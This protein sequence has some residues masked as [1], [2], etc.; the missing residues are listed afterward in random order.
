V[1]KHL[2]DL[3]SVKFYMW[4]VA[5]S[6]LA[7]FVWSASR[8][9]LPQLDGRYA[10]I[11]L[12]TVG[13][14]SRIVVDIQLLKAN[15]SV[16][17]VFLFL[18]ALLFGP[19]A[20][21]VLAWVEAFCTSLRFA[22]LTRI[23]VFNAGCMALSMGVAA[24]L[25][26]YW[27][28][29]LSVLVQEK[30]SSR[31]LLALAV[32]ALAHYAANSFMISMGNGL[33]S[34]RSWWAVWREHYAWMV[35]AYL[36]SG[37]IA[38]LLANFIS[39][40]SFNAFLAGLPIIGIIYLSYRNY[41]RQLE[42]TQQQM[43][44]AQLHLR[45]M[46]ESEERFRAAFGEAPIGMALASQDGRWLQVNRSLRE[47]FGYTEEEFG[48]A[49]YQT[50][51]HPADVVRLHTMAGQVL[52]RKA[53]KQ[54]GEIRFFHRDGAEV[55]TAAS[56][57]LI[58]AENGEERLIFQVQD[59]TARR[60]AE[61]QLR[62]AAFYDEL[63]GLGNRR[64]FTDALRETLAPVYSGSACQYA[65]AFVDLQRFRLV[66]ERLGHAVGDQL[67]YQVAQRLRQSAP[68][69]CKIARL[70]GDE[71]T[72]LWEIS[73][74]AE[75]LRLVQNLHQKLAECFY[76]NGQEIFV[77]ANTGLALGDN[78][79]TTPEE[80]LRD[81]DV[82]LQ[83]AKANETKQYAVFN[84]AMREH[85]LNRIQMEIDLRHALERQEF[86]PVYQPIMS[87]RD[88]RLVGF[89]CLARWQ[90]PQRGLVSPA[91]FIPLAEETGHIAALGN[92]VMKEACRQLVRW[93]EQFA[94]DLPLTMSVNVSGKQVMQSNLV[95]QVAGVLS[96]TG[97]APHNLKL[98][99]TE[100]V[101]L[102]NLEVA[103]DEFKR[104]RALGVQL[105]MDDFGT[106]YSSL[107][108]LQRLPITTLKIDRSFVTP[109]ADKPES[110]AIV[111]TIVMLANNL[112][113][114]VIAEG[115]ETVEQ[116]EK[117]RE[118]GCGHGQGFLFAKPLKVDEAGSLLRDTFNVAPR[119]SHLLRSNLVGT[120]PA[121]RRS[122][123][124]AEESRSNLV[125]A[126]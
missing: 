37:S 19:E 83:Q 76:V 17:D 56:L 85:A 63:T 39:R 96:E 46:A 120:T 7:V 116:L 78:A 26:H 105:S 2:N 69:K 111:Q 61:E 38:L 44:E 89:E 77:N 58:R 119:V 102:D 24:N 82:A 41:Q 93:Q 15:F 42:A 5:L 74:E 32:L 36:A 9:P 90:H 79:R 11:C 52:Q 48:A 25:S 95:E 55:W 30:L 43:T 94:S 115:I 81:A 112:G 31:F 84:Q 12:F 60:Q 117:L 28:G 72:L 3:I 126:L 62:H 54:Q 35:L 10:L 106:G 124:S 1:N 91:D 118:F 75:A 13:L 123:T 40:W 50:Y 67:L 107:S 64:Y 6:G 87:L 68:E 27:F 125:G 103:A 66:N 59:I 51:A 33:R 49:H 121:A 114:E 70:G 101:M 113:L 109:L 92:F 100:S 29:S 104:L 21:V 98:E 110:A 8:L 80:W 71:F 65:V 97:L 108:Y 45:E 57:S 22:K 73:A 23:R 34:Q 47:L 20:A 14:G 53:V 18:T 86:F 88:N 16:S 4:A 122:F 99:M